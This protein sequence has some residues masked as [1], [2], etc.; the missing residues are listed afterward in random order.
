MGGD[1]ADVEPQRMRD[2][3]H[4]GVLERRQNDNARRAGSWISF[5]TLQGYGR[6]RP[7]AAVRTATLRHRDR[8]LAVGIDEH[9]A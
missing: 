3:S 6:F 9:S 8:R 7:S 2:G 4:N 5:H 1:A